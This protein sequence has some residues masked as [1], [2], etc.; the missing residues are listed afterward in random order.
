MSKARHAALVT[1]IGLTRQREDTALGA[2]G[3][4]IAQGQ[5]AQKQL[6]LL[7]EYRQDYQQRLHTLSENGMTGSN[8]RNFTRFLATLDEAIVQQTRLVNARQDHIA[9]SSA[10]WQTARQKHHAAKTVKQRRDAAWQAQENRREQR[11]TDE[12]AS[13]SHQRTLS[14]RGQA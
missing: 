7:Q 13:R 8:Y 1:L 12:L 4:A 11:L 3:E 9:S 2:L 6:D 5:A 10:Q 14:R